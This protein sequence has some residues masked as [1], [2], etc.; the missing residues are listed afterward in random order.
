VFITLSPLYGS[1]HDPALIETLSEGTA[2]HR[3]LQN[4]ACWVTP[5]DSLDFDAPAT[6][7]IFS[8]TGYDPSIL[9]SYYEFIDAA[10]K[11]PGSSVS[12][13]D[14]QI[15]FLAVFSPALDFLNITY[16]MVPLGYDPL[17]GDIQFRLVREDMAQGYRVYKN[18][19]AS[20][21][22]FMV[23]NILHFSSDELLARALREGADLK[24]T[25]LISDT[26]A[27]AKSFVSTCGPTDT[28]SVNPTK[29]GI[30]DI[31][32]E[33]HATCQ[34]PL[35]TS[36]VW[37]PGWHAYVD[38]KEIPIYKTNMAFRTLLVPNGDHIIR[39]VYKPT[40][41]LLG[42]IVSM[43]SILGAVIVSVLKRRKTA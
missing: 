8:A 14:V 39:M 23:R 35:V 16:V 3:T 24:K 37:Y 41:F 38:G 31:T 13:M 43:G 25:V 30:N 1:A 28:F 32:L 15:P 29:Y 7:G 10:N 18:L 40:I 6:Y 21:R 12:E 27:D 5:R 36:E 34:A 17:A 4:F 19:S 22:F 20:P 26:E 11:N 33:T 2:P 42:G 9:R